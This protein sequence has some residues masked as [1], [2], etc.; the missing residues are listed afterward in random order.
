MK[1]V[2]LGRKAS[3]YPGAA[4]VGANVDG[5]PNFMTISHCGLAAY[6][7]P[8]LV[9][10]LNK[11]RHTLKGIKQNATFS[12]NMPSCDMVKNTDY[13]GIYS[14]KKR[15]KSEIFTVFYGQLPGSV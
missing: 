15:D 2:K 8:A 3:L 12:V 5:K 4:L 11:F 6:K 1:K 7:P 9:V 13:C 14:G 10:P